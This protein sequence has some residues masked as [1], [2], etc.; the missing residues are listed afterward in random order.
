MTVSSVVGR[1]STVVSSRKVLLIATTTPKREL[2]LEVLSTTV[3]A[4]ATFVAC[5]CPSSCLGARSWQVAL[6][7]SHTS[8]PGF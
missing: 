1:L 8:S 4:F 7:E 3:A 6:I 5:P 2:E